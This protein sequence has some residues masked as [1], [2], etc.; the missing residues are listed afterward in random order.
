MQA[1]DP[2][3]LTPQAG[4]T[5]SDAALRVALW[6]TPMPALGDSADA[7]QRLAQAA[8][9]ATAQGAHWLLTPEMAL[10]GYLIDPAQ[11]HALAEPADGPQAQAVAA[12][13][14][15]FGIGIVYGWPER[16][17]DGG[18]PYNAVQA[19]G[20][21]GQRLVVH[22]KVYLFGAADAERFS[23]AAEVAPPFEWKGWCIGQL[24]SYDVEQ[25][26]AVR[27]LAQQGARVI[28]APTAN[29][30]PYDDAPLL[31]VPRLAAENHVA[32]A[33]AN[34]C[35][36]EGATVYAGYS[37]VCGPRGEVMARAGRGEALLIADIPG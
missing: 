14:R 35:G 23:P 6:Q 3:S 28:F 11:L 31:T 5:T 37:T 27:A 15:Q 17:A 29:M 25:P 19:I 26:A 30:L 22:R 2:T 4:G 21:D 7:L 20:P 18:K 36:R 12:L 9:S 32:I 8:Q 10:T 13:A 16:R 1:I 24:I 33:Y 34:A